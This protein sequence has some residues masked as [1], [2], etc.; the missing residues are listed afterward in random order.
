MAL[1]FLDYAGQTT[2]EI[3]AS[4][5]TH[6]VASLL[7]ALEQGIMARQSESKRAD[8]TPAER[9]LLAVLALEREVNNGGFAQF[10]VNSSGQYAAEIVEYL[11]RINCT[12]TAALAERAVDCL[13]LNA[14]FITPDTVRAAIVREDAARDQRL[15]ALDKEFYQLSEIEQYLFRFVEEHADSFHLE[16][17]EVAPPEAKRGVTNAGRLEIALR[18]SAPA[19]DSFADVK[20]QAVKLAKEKSIAAWDEDC[21]AA[22]HLYLFALHV[23]KGDLLAVAEVAPDAFRLCRE[24]TSHCVTYRQWIEK[25]LEASR[26]DEADQAALRYVEYLHGDDRA[27]QFIRKRVGFLAAVIRPNAARLPNTAHYLANNFTAADIEPPLVIY[28]GLRSL[29][30]AVGDKSADQKT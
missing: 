2:A 12:K 6:N 29:I 28:K 22:A 1:P 4:K 16:K 19:S 26:D 13:G 10:F 21:S 18:F 17:R 8:C 23:R 25:L 5:N 14:S 27:S 20:E 15:N 9:L 3:L 7:H 24:A 11:N 30:R